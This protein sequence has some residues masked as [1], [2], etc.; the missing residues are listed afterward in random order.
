MYFKH[1]KNEVYKDALDWG[2]KNIIG[3]NK[4]NNKIFDGRNAEFVKNS[5]TENL[6]KSDLIY[7]KIDVLNNIKSTWIMI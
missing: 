1:S 7:A 6:G 5:F 4:Y 2:K 3:K